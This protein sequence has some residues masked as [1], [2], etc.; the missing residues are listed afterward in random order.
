MA[1]TVGPRTSLEV[2]QTTRRT[3]RK[4]WRVVLGAILRCGLLLRA[5]RL[6]TRVSPCLAPLYNTLVRFYVLSSAALAIRFLFRVLRLP[7]CA[8]GISLFPPPRSAACQKTLARKRLNVLAVIVAWRRRHFLFAHALHTFTVAWCS[9][10]ACLFF[11]RF[12]LLPPP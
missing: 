6:G 5:A 7:C 8:G 12:C 11:S 4:R 9:S 1:S 3:G 10:S 2:S